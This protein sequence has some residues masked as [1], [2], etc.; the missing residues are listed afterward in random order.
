MVS[1]QKKL[2][3][4]YIKFVELFSIMAD[5]FLGDE[6]QSTVSEV[7]I[8]HQA[9]PHQTPLPTLHFLSRPRPVANLKLF[10]S[11]LNQQRHISQSSPSTEI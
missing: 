9:S 7:V 8:Q 4:I 3:W 5:E 11:S 6:S 10:L 1:L 2:T